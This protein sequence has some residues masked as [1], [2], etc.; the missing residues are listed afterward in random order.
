M[1]SEDEKQQIEKEK[2]ERRKYYIKIFSKFE[3]I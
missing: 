1:M 2:D 3:K